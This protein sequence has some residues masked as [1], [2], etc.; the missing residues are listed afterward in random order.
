M[1]TSGFI[2]LVSPSIAPTSA[3]FE[4]FGPGNNEYIYNVDLTSATSFT[5]TG[6]FDPTDPFDTELS[7]SHV[8]SVGT[9]GSFSIDDTGAFTY[10]VN[11]AD[12]VT[13]TETAITIDVTGILGSG[14]SDTD[15]IK[16]NFTLCF[17]AGSLIAT[18]DGECV[19]ENL[20]IG[21][22]VTTADGRTVPVRWIGHTT[23]SP[24]FNPAD[25][26]EPVR[27]RAGAL[28]AGLPHTDLI[29]TADH[30]MILDDLVIN[31]GAL[32][33][34]STIDWYP[35]K[36][37][38]ASMTYY[39]VETEGHEAILANGAAAESLLDMPSRRSFENFAEYQALYGA[40]QSIAEMNA[41]RISSPRLLPQSIRERLGIADEA[42]FA[43]FDDPV[44]HTA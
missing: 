22:L 33:N 38:G 32:V 30:G 35:W 27:I 14:G 40:E 11:R 13:A 17:A 3:T 18:P 12:L 9:V 43:K 39:H 29:V 23:I 20:K 31:A 24:M 8:F 37:L 16:F 1:G 6:N 42:T 44:R 36:T 26:L 25:R 7:Y 5:L 15:F 21:D 19:I 34:G 41:P 28:G 10:T 2:D 4:P